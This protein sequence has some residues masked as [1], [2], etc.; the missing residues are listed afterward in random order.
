MRFTYAGCSNIGAVRRENEDAILMRAC[1]NAG[2]FLVADGIG[3][4]AFGSVISGMI[5]DS[6]A[7]WWEEEFLPHQSELGFSAVIQALKEVLSQIN[8]KVIISYGEME[9][10][11]T[12]TLLF[13]FKGSC[14]WISAGDSRLYR[15]RAL[16]C[17]QLTRDDTVANL[18]E[19]PHWARNAS[20]GQLVGAVG[21]R[22]TLEYSIG[23]DVIKRGDRFFV[24][25]DGVYRFIS[26]RKLE[27]LLLLPCI[28]FVPDII[29]KKVSNIVEINGA[30]DNYSMILVRADNA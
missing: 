3:G 21:I 8:R 22:N 9:A 15:A 2:L 27:R 17:K 19:K 5:R 18:V 4:A 14:V 13:I 12:I 26:S 7:Q 23:T 28:S 20:G 30:G 1:E 29:L 10:G 25:S 24:C 6:Y 11:S 16:S